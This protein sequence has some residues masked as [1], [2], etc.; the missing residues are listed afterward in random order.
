MKMTQKRIKELDKCEKEEQLFSLFNAHKI[1]KAKRVVN[2]RYCMIGK[3][4]GRDVVASIG[5]DYWKVGNKV[6]FGLSNLSEEIVGGYSNRNKRH[7]LSKQEQVSAIAHVF[8]M[9]ERTMSRGLK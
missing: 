7:D 5:D 8:S 4:E 6:G 3:I 2:D 9:P 1:S